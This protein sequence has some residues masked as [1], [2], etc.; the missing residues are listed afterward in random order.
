MM[1][2]VTMMAVTLRKRA[3]VISCEWRLIGK[4]NLVK[5]CVGITQMT[6]QTNIEI[7]YCCYKYKYNVTNTMLQI[8]SKHLKGRS[9][10]SVLSATFLSF[11]RCCPGIS[12][13]YFSNKWWQIKDNKAMFS[14]QPRFDLCENSQIL[15]SRCIFYINGRDR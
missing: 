7:R 10:L 8:Q 6:G 1:M 13:L 14:L 2:I 11:G 5:T 15:A 4:D 3:V 9:G 12:K